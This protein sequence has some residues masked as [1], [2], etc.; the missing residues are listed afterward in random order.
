MAL[1]LTGFAHLKKRGEDVVSLEKNVM[2]LIEN[3]RSKILALNGNMSEKVLNSRVV[4]ER[5]QKL[6]GGG[7]V[8]GRSTDIPLYW[9]TQIDLELQHTWPLVGNLNRVLYS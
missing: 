5:G 3:L 2:L 1:H 7:M 6:W 8:S 4:R 9:V